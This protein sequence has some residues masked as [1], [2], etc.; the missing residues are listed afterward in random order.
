M[1]G[2]N[3]FTVEGLQGRGA[4]APAGAGAGAAP[5][6]PRPLIDSTAREVLGAVLSTRRTYVQELLVGEAVATVDAA[7]RQAA[8]ALL[9]P[10]LGNIAAAQAAMRSRGQ[11]GGDAPLPPALAMIG[12]WGPWCGRVGGWL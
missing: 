7:A 8:A 4:P 11:L 2:V 3:S 10:A 1:Q 12:R 5:Q 9:A 6:P